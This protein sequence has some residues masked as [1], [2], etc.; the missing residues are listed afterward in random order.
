M[1]A[2]NFP[3][4]TPIGKPKD[5]VDELD[6]KCGTIFCVQQYDAHLNANWIHSIYK[7]TKEDL[8]ALNNGGVLRLSVLGGHP[9]FQMVCLT[10]ER[11][12]EVE[13]EP[14]WDLGA[15]I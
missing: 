3:G 6:G 13:P 2:C 7:P 1:Q 9:V 11:T 8:E 5:W 12:A 14:M 4:A 10:P 15:P